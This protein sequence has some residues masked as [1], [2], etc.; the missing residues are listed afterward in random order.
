MQFTSSY[1]YKIRYGQKVWVLSGVAKNFCRF[2]K[3]A[4]HDPVHPCTTWP[5]HAD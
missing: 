1:R 4:I 3:A 5:Q 2:F